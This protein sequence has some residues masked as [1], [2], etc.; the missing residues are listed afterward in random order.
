MLFSF[1]YS[2]F[3]Q[4]ALS[5]SC[6]K[7]SSFVRFVIFLSIAL[8]PDLPSRQSNRQFDT[9]LPQYYNVENNKSY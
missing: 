7:P 5:G 1:V 6:Q 3:S 2:L 4:K 8:V 9:L